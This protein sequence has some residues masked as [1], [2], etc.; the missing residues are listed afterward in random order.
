[1]GYS[2]R[3]HKL[4]HL[5]DEEAD[6]RSGQSTVLESSKRLDHQAVNHHIWIE[7]GRKTWQWT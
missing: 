6:L 5:V 7:L 2:G 3:V 1:M 4:A